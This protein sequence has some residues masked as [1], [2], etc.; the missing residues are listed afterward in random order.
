MG[1]SRESPL[2]IVQVVLEEVMISLG[3]PGFVGFE[4]YRFDITKVCCRQ[5]DLKPDLPTRSFPGC[6]SSR[7]K[8]RSLLLQPV[9]Y[10]RRRGCRGA[11]R[12]G[13]TRQDVRRLCRR[14][15]RPCALGGL[16][17]R[18]HAESDQEDL[19]QSSALHRRSTSRIEESPH[20]SPHNEVFQISS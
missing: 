20:G 1:W 14:S 19:D 16:V 9:D 12:P 2:C 4:V 18:G 7:R 10:G 6:P 5:V 3:A 11:R 13:R 8:F 17:P 15:G